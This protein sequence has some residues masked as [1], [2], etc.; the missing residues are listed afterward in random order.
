M[1]T[2]FAPCALVPSSRDADGSRGAPAAAADGHPGTA[3]PRRVGGAAG[4]CAVLRRRVTRRPA[5]VDRTAAA[6]VAAGV[7][8]TAA[9][10]GRLPLPVLEP[11]GR[12]LSGACWQASCCGAASAIWWSIGPDLTWR[13]T[14]RGLAYAAFCVLGLFVAVVGAA[15]AARRRRG[16]GGA[17]GRRRGVGAGREGRA[18]ALSRLVPLRETARPARVLERAC[19]RGRRPGCRS[20]SGSRP[21]ACTRTSFAL[22]APCSSLRPR[23]ALL[24]TYSRG[25]VAVAVVAVAV[26]LVLTDRRLEGVVGARAGGLPALAVSAWAFGRPGLSEDGQPYSVRFDDGIRFGVVLG[27]ARRPC[28][29]LGVPRRALRGA[30]AAD[31]RARAPDAALGRARRAGV[32]AV[33][34]V[35]VLF[36]VA[37][38]VDWVGDQVR[39]L[40]QPDDAARLAGARRLAGVGSNNRWGWWEEAWEAFTDDPI[41]GTGAG[42]FRLVH[43]E[44][45]RQPQRRHRAAQPAPPGARRDGPRRLPA[46][47]RS[48]GSPRCSRSRDACAGSTGRNGLPGLRWRSPRCSIRCTA[49]STTTGTSSPSARRSSSRS[50]FCSRPA[51]RPGS[52]AGRS[53]SARGRGGRAGRRVFAP[54]AVARGPAGARRRGRARV[55]PAP[56]PRPTGPTQARA[57]ESALGR[58]ALLAA[59]AREGAQGS[60]LEALRLYVRATSSSPRTPD[61]WYEL[62]AFE[63]EPASYGW[64]ELHLTRARE[65]DPLGPAKR[66]RSRSCAPSVARR[67]IRTSRSCPAYNRALVQPVPMRF[68]LVCVLAALVLAVPAAAQTDRSVAVP[69]TVSVLAADGERG[70]R[71]AFL[72]PRGER[73]LR[74]GRHLEAA[75]QVAFAGS[76]RSPAGRGRAPG[77]ARTGLSLAAAPCCGRPTRAGTS[78]STRVWRSV[79]QGTPLW[80]RAAG[81]TC[82]PRRRLCSSPLLVGE[83]DDPPASYAVRKHSVRL[84]RA[85]RPPHHGGCLDDRPLGLLAHGPYRLGVAG[86][87]PGRSSGSPLIDRGRRSPGWTTPRA[88]RV[89][90]KTPARWSPSCAWAL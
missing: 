89:A 53:S 70:Q 17:R 19:A 81:R 30:P 44:A 47:R 86:S 33:V 16:A 37:D 60:M 73:R 35:A 75:R 84:R 20:R 66:R 6:V 51:R 78:A 61:T 58:A 1:L 8:G 80:T 45:A 34:A 26:W 88:R 64:A 79:R 21:R 25:G 9:F 18:G 7:A 29:R 32:A 36:V 59:G 67:V 83:G 54:D 57:L 69:A 55:R 82:Q 41:G 10:L 62:G 48:A 52:C 63:L 65:L 68:V 43:R 27:V 13:Y 90:A 12:G 22:P 56:P 49:S 3:S 2:R 39:R 77:A 14:N 31:A 38:P 5:G 71:I 42:T 28:L 11:R 40:H 50:A 85:R 74:R 24:L 46:R 4:R 76:A 23:V 15:G 87:R 72:S